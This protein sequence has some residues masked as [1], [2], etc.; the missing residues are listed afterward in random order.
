MEEFLVTSS[1][2]DEQTWFSDDANKG[3]RA[4][5]RY[6]V[7]PVIC[8]SLYLTGER[9]SL[10]CLTLLFR[11]FKFDFMCMDVSL[12]V[13]MRIVCTPGTCR[14]QER[15]RQVPWSWVQ[16]VT[17]LHGGAGSWTISSRRAARLVAESFISL[18]PFASL[19]LVLI[20][21]F[22][23]SLCQRHRQT[24]FCL[25]TVSGFIEWQ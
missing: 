21:F 16:I 24:H 10:L 7:W 25:S 22:L 12:H 3:E 13:H 14:S 6:D 8:A 11:F 4:S 19:L 23:V 17:T 9:S 5:V 15:R 1:L 18:D 20:F 2:N